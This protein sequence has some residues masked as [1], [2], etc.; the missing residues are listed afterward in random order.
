M[1]TRHLV[2]LASFGILM[3]FT[4]EF[5]VAHFVTSVK[6]VAVDLRRRGHLQKP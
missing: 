5:F 4:V 2:F 3:E 1:D 6:S